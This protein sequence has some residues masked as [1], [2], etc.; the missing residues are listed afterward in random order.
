[1]KTGPRPRGIAF[2]PDGKTAFVGNE[3]GASITVIDAATHKV[4]G[5]HQD[6]ADGGHADRAAA[7]GRGDHSP[8]ASSCSSRWAGRSRS[9]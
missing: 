2:T 8:T 6:S 5:D 1:M 3:N 4:V 9:P 7:D